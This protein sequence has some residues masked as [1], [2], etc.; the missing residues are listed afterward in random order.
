MVVLRVIHVDNDD[1]KFSFPNVAYA[2]DW[3]DKGDRVWV[4]KS[5]LSIQPGKPLLWLYFLLDPPRGF[6][7]RPLPLSLLR[8]HVHDTPRMNPP[9]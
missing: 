5:Y 8:F 1:G 7:S 4:K 9:P 3:M 6:Q 2:S